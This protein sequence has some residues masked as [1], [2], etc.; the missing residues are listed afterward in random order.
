MLEKEDPYQIMDPKSFKSLQV[1]TSENLRYGIQIKLKM[2]NS[3]LW[4]SDWGYP[5]EK[6][7]LIVKDT[8]VKKLICKTLEGWMSTRI[9]I[10][11][12][13]RNQKLTILRTG[14]RRSD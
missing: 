5:E 8:I 4:L 2:R 13:A 12:T 14:K 11:M 6:A 3:W 7:G 9:L 1:D 10:R